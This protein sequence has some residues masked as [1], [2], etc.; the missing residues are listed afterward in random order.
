MVNK[1]F[2]MPV[3]GTPVGSRVSLIVAR[4]TILRMPERLREF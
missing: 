1:A 3:F 2:Q 4:A